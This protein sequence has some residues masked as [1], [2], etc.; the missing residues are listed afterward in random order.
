MYR[1]EGKVALI[2]GA[3]T[4]IGECSAKLFAKHG[5]KVVVADI[6]DAL[7]QSV[8]EA[9]GSS[10][11]AYVHCDVTKEEDVKNAVDFAVSTYGKLD[12]MFNNAGIVD[13]LK[14]VLKYELSDFQRVLNVNINGVFLGMIDEANYTSMQLVSTF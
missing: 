9:I 8:V 14:P 13:S 6:D 10:N 1:L 4:G 2:T 5:A 11:A 12:I 3:A 7:G